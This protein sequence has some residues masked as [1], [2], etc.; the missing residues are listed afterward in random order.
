MTSIRI[1]SVKDARRRERHP[2]A[3]LPGAVPLTVELAHSH[4]CPAIHSRA[5]LAVRARF[6]VLERTILID[7]LWQDLFPLTILKQPLC[8]TP[9]Q[10]LAVQ[11]S[12]IPISWVS[13]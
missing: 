5:R 6:M 4:A 9:L 1:R 7:A 3:A 13:M 10:S 11:C 8:S 2:R 12:G